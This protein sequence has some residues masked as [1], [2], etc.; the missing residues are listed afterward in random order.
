MSGAFRRGFLVAGLA[1]VLSVASA[2]DKVESPLDPSEST[3]VSSAPTA[4]GIGSLTTHLI[5]FDR[6]GIATARLQFTTGNL[7]FYVTSPTCTTNPFSCPNRAFAQST[8]GT[9][10]QLRVGVTEGETLKFWVENRI[11]A[12][13]NYSI[14]VRVE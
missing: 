1:A 10:E 7:D 9:L 4:G 12:S 8:S 5:T 13:Q 6:R 3:P 14:T 2:C 11:T